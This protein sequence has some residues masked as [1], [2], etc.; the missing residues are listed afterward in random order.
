MS[1]SEATASV[2]TTSAKHGYQGSEILGLNIDKQNN[3]TYREWAPNA[4]EA[5]LTGEFSKQ[6]SITMTSLVLI[7]SKITGTDT[8]TP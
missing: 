7:S 2:S 5:Y 4:K 6:S 1:S 8:L 3:I